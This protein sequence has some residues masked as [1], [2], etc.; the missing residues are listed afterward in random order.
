[1]MGSGSFALIANHKPSLWNIAKSYSAAYHM[2]YF[3]VAPVTEPEEDK[4]SYV[5]SMRPPDTDALADV[6]D[7]FNW[8]KIHFVYNIFPALDRLEQLRTA[9]RKRGKYVDVSLI[10][11][12][13][14]R[15]VSDDLR[16]INTS[17]MLTPHAN[18]NILLDLETQDDTATVIKAL[19]DMKMSTKRYHI[20]ITGMDVKSYDYE[21]LSSTGARVTGMTLIEESRHEVKAFLDGW[22]S[23]DPRQWPGAGEKQVTSTAAL[24]YDAVSVFS[25]VLDGF[26]QKDADIFRNT[27]RRGLVYNN[28]EKGIQCH[29]QPRP[30]MH[31]IMLRDGFK[32]VDIQGLTGRVVFTDSG[33]R[34]NYK[35]T[36]MTAYNRA[37]LRKIGVWTDIRGL[38]ITDK[39]A[40]V[41]TDIDQPEMPTDQVIEIERIL[42]DNTNGP[43]KRLDPKEACGGNGAETLSI[44]TPW[45][46]IITIVCTW[47][48]LQGLGYLS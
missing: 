12:R 42:G 41:L 32:Q 37:S 35:L 17:L 13:E 29:V 22:S 16:Q 30:W 3:T 34:K 46:V 10:R 38:K 47:S 18:C 8:R 31:G 19:V 44:I 14:L 6:I 9:L 11:V 43:A 21:S 20:L 40:H 27:F 33:Q 23:L 5:M 28:N 45:T 36:I 15:N 26:L 2:P 4:E 24:V 25:A 39:N 7:F 48:Y 1:M